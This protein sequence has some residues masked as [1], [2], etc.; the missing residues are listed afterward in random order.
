VLLLLLERVENC[1]APVSHKLTVPLDE[2]REVTC[3][4]KMRGRKKELLVYVPIDFHLACVCKFLNYA[5]FCCKRLTQIIFENS[6]PTS[7]TSQR[8]FTIFI[9]LFQNFFH[10]HTNKNTKNTTFREKLLPSSGPTLKNLDVGPDE[11]RC[12]SRNVVFLLV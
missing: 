2:Y 4:L 1:T 12:F 7:R 6:I 11:G 5:Y 9:Y 10:R 3:K 8:I